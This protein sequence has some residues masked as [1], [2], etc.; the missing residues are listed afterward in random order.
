[1]NPNVTAIFE[2]VF[3][4]VYL[5]TVWYLVILMAV[6]LPKVQ[7]KNKT[8]AGLVLLAFVLLAAGDTGHVGFRV[9]AH[10]LGDLNKTVSVFG[11]PMS[12]LG[13]GMLTT[14]YTVTLFYMVFVYVWQE[15]FNQKAT[16][17]TWLLLA[18]GVARLIFMAL[19]ANDWGNTV[20]PQPVSLYRNIFLM[21]QGVGLIW[22][23]FTSAYK[24]NDNTF[25][26]IGWMVVVSYAF[27][28]PVILFAQ[29]IPVIGML[30]IPKTIAYVAIAIFAYFGLWKS[31]KA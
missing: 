8:V 31:K 28:T 29:Q 27:Y 5:L 11:S 7:A 30:M 19:P 23:I 21:V 2:T 14:A 3:N 15:R 16:W 22:L 12:L 26:W 20:P 24:A 4:V 1:M 6:K 17:F 25:K 13:I 9:A 18:A 10:L